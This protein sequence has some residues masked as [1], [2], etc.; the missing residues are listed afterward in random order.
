MS[1]KINQTTPI[2]SDKNTDLEGLR[3]VIEYLKFIRWMATP[4]PLKASKTQGEFAKEIRVD[5][6][7]LTAWKK[8]EGFW[9]RVRKETKNWGKE[10]TATVLLSLYQ[11]IIKSGNAA[12]VKLWLSYIND[13]IEKQDVVVSGTLGQ[14]LD[15]IATRNQPLVNDKN[16]Y[17]LRTNKRG[18]TAGENKGQ[19]VATE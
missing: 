14:L 8:R 15:E 3:N 5:E 11:T 13:W 4:M 9:D 16:K 18:G 2:H 6:D 19:E 1:K 17:P 10:K 12:E 7:T